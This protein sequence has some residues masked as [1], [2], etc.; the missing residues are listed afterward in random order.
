LRDLQQGFLDNEALYRSLNA[1]F[2][3]YFR[4]YEEDADAAAGIHI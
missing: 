1:E 4:K 2:I 3:M